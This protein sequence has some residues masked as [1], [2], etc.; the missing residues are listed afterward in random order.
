VAR[1]LLLLLLLLLLSHLLQWSPAGA[2]LLVDEQ[3][4]QQVLHLVVVPACL[5]EQ[6]Q[7]PRQ[8]MT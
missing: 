5:Q 1:Q 7:W 4:P 2:Q 8:Q 6:Q 3:L